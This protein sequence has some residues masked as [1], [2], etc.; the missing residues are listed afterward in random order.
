MGL[1]F[2]NHEQRKHEFAKAKAF[3]Q[4][5]NNL[6]LT[7]GW[8]KHESSQGEDLSRKSIGALHSF[9]KI[10]ESIYAIGNKKIDLGRYLLGQGSFAKIK[11]IEGKNG[12]NFA[13]KITASK[14][15]KDTLGQSELN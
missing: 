13:L 2:L 6:G 3:F 7:K 15:D 1:L 14:F 5:K 9:I 12:Q 11:V 8:H 4:K 10:N